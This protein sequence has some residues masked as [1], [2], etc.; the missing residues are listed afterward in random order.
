MV[1]YHTDSTIQAPGNP[2][3]VKHLVLLMGYVSTIDNVSLNIATELALCF[4]RQLY[5]EPKSPSE[6]KNA[7]F[8]RVRM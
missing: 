7:Q 2:R 4:I 5:K 8:V 6:N 1:V 3:V